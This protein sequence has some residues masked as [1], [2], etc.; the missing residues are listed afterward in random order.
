MSHATQA[1][2]ND[3]IWLQNSEFTQSAFTYVKNKEILLSCI[4]FNKISYSAN[5]HKNMSFQ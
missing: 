1:T 2:Q 3:E 4:T 5:L